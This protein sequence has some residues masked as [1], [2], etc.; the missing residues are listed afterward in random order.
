VHGVADAEVRVGTE[1]SQP[2][3]PRNQLQVE[4]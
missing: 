2:R 3:V 1:L 4:E